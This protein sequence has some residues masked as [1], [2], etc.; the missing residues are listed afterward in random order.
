MFG[1]DI[2][3]HKLGLVDEHVDEGGIIEQLRK[4]PLDHHGSLEALRADNDGE[5]YLRHSSDADPIEKVV[6]SERLCAGGGETNDS[7]PPRLQS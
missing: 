4:D 6:V 5:K 2:T 1:C 7:Q 3:P